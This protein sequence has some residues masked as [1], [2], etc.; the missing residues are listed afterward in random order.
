MTAPIHIA[1]H[2]RSGTTILGQLFE[3]IGE[4]RVEYETSAAELGMTNVGSAVNPRFKQWADSGHGRTVDKEPRNILRLAEVCRVTGG[5][6]LHIVRDGRD[7]ACSVV[8]ANAKRNQSAQEWLAKRTNDQWD[9]AL[10]RADSE[11]MAALPDL[12]LV[13]SFWARLEVMARSKHSS[14]VMVVRYEDLVELPALTGGAIAE[15]VGGIDPALLARR[16]MKL[17]DDDPLGHVAHASSNNH[18]T[19]GHTVRVGRWR[20]QFTD[21]ELAQLYYLAG[22]TYES[23]GYY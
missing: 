5:K 19:D 20:Q 8:G 4:C 6:G 13:G 3:G 18:N 10:S 11:S 14:A 7:V 22:S 17:M 2:G 15:H 16:A 9:W 21:D 1:G 23:F 12:V